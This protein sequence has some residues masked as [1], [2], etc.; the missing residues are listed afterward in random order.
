MSP[1]GVIRHKSVGSY[2]WKESFEGVMIRPCPQSMLNKHCSLR[3]MAIRYA[4]GTKT[5]GF[6]PIKNIVRHAQCLKS[7]IWHVTVPLTRDCYWPKSE[8][9]LS[10]HKPATS[11]QHQQNQ[12][13]LQGT[14]KKTNDYLKEK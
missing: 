7:L 1:C 8:K 12:D 4:G 13:G 9:F 11:Q 10:C 14:K 6:S 5:P 2:L 3:L